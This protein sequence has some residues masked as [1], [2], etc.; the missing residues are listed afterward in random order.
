MYCCMPIDSSS[1]EED[2]SEDDEEEEENGD[3]HRG[4]G[5]KSL[6]DTFAD[7]AKMEL[8]PGK[9]KTGQVKLFLFIHLFT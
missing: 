3:D 7:D 9:K 5:G 6:A 2:S 8:S 4:E 1:D